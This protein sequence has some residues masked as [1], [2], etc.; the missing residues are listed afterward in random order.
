MT[1]QAQLEG[2][3]KMIKFARESRGLS[4]QALADACGLRQATIADIETGKQNWSIKTLIAIV[5]ALNYYL[6]ISLTPAK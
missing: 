1:E 2:I 6:D 3:G 4:Q 5:N